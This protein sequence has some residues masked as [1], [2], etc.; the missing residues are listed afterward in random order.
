MCIIIRKFERIFKSELAPF[1]LALFDE[2]GMRKTQ[3]F[4]F[5]TNFESIKGMPSLEN[6]VY[7]IDGD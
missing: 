1:P 4:V 2:G 3:K 7:V 5:Y 6:L